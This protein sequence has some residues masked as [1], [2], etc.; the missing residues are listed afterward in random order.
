MED[1]NHQKLIVSLT[2]FPARIL[3]VPKVIDRLLSQTRPPDEIVL[4]LSMDQFPNREPDLP[5]ALRSLVSEGKLLLRWVEGDLKPHKKYIYAFREFPKEII[6]TVD[7]DA[8]YSATLLE[9]LW[10]THLKYPEA[11][12]AGR[13]HLITL[14]PSGQP[15]PYASWL[16][17]TSGFDEGPSMQL[18]A[19]GIGGVLYDPRWFPPELYDE[20]VI[21][22]TCLLADDLWLKIMEMAAGIPVVR[23]SG[24][25]LL[26]MIPGSQET[27]LCSANLRENRNDEIFASIRR[28]ADVYYGRDIVRESLAGGS[29]PRVVGEQSL[30][31]YA[32]S[33]RQH[34][35]VSAGSEMMKLERELASAEKQAVRLQAEYDLVLN[36]LSYKLGRA[37]LS[38]LN[39]LREKK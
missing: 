18:F 30:I 4:Y 32:N 23:S 3:F 5:E 14:D 39:R 1:S 36:S 22:D 24:T 6:V 7:D 34:L 13:T 16:R 25:E 33:D 31:D 9:D 38:P 2:S 19:V 15:L 10:Q 8:Q 26:R 27:A 37:L 35:L 17:R 28:W 20:R 29:W 11:V 12:V 21:R